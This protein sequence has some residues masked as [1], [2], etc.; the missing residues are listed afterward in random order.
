MTSSSNI[1]TRLVR[2]LIRLRW[3]ALFGV[4]AVT[5]VAGWAASSIGVDNAVE[6]WFLDSDP[7]LVAYHDFQE[8]FGNDEVVVIAVSTEDGALSGRGLAAL[9]DIDSRASAVPGIAEVQSVTATIGASGTPTSLDVGP[10]IPEDADVAA[11]AD[12]AAAAAARI[13]DDPL[14]TRLISDDGDVALVLAR[15]EAMDDIDAQRDGILVGLQEAMQGADATLAYAGIGVV[16][17]ALN[18]ASTQ[19]AAVFIVVSYVLIAVLLWWLLG[20]IGPTILTLCAVGA[21]ATWLMGTYGGAGRDINMVTMVLPTLVLVIGVSSCVHMLVHVSEQDKSLSGVERTVAGVGFIFWPC[22]FNTL[23]TCM[24]FLA[25]ST[26]AMP[27]IRDLGWFGALGLAAAFIA[28]LILCST[29]APLSFFQPAPRSSSLI[30]RGVDFLADLAVR[31]SRLVLTIAGFVALL[32]SLGITQIE[33]DT[34]S[35]GF[36]KKSHSVRQDSEM[37][38]SSFGPYTPLEF[39]IV[40]EDSVRTPEIFTAIAAWQ[41]AIEGR[42][43]V[44]W[45]HSAAD[46]VRRLNQIMTDGSDEQHA[47][48]TNS[49]AMEQLLFL[50]SSNPDSDMSQLIADGDRVARVT[51]GIPM[52]SAREFKKTIDELTALAELPPDVTITASGYL[53]LYVKMMD[54]I[55]Q[56]QLTSFGV[57]FLVIFTLVGL[58]FRSLRMAVLSVPANLLPVLLTLGLMGLLG[59]R[60]DVATVTIAAIVLGLVV[61]DT[62][63]FLYR[64]NHERGRHES[65]VDAVHAAVRGVGRPMA[66]TT[67]VLGLGFCVLGLATVKSVAYFG[68]LLAFAL[69]AALLSDLVVIPALLVQLDQDTDGAAAPQG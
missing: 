42:E 57:A 66:I 47:I 36:L 54:Y 22:L 2:L 1:S 34:Y 44:G 52:G 53:P 49:V 9:Q 19:G 31:R 68:L 25:L 5:A 18:Q 23:T 33:V 17:A 64:Y 67:I 3:L 27:V 41:D 63:Q 45:S 14:L 32:A 59:I 55:V 13:L 29:L 6:V 58:L 61:D 24:G 50:Y 16:Y 43:D 10:A 39:T 62:V 60:L 38:E 11:E 7:A 30:Q 21:G 8:L 56:S 20:R 40:A 51:V 28:G 35:I 37:I 46:V 4:L 69:T 48:P 65:E 15:M 26:A 12:V